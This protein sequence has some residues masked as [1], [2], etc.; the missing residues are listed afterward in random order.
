V[1]K[2]YSSIKREITF[3]IIVLMLF[4][5]GGLSF[6]MVKTQTESLEAEIKL[7]GLSIAKNLAGGIGD[8]LLTDDELGMAR[9]LSDAMENKGVR[10]AFVVDEKEIIKAHNRI[11]R[12]GGRYEPAAVFNVVETEPYRIIIVERDGEKIINFEVPAVARGRLTL[13]TVHLGISYSLITDVLNDVYVKIAVIAFVVIVL[14]IAGAFFLG[15]AITKPIAVLAKGAGIIGTGNLDYKVKVKTK[16]ELGALAGVLNMMTRD[17]KSA[18]EVVIKQ[19]RM[20]K[21]LEVARDIQLSLI[22]GNLEEIKGYEVAAYY[23]SAKEVGGDYYDLMPLGE[24]KY[25]FVMGDVSGKGIPAALIMTMCRSILHAESRM[26]ETPDG[27]IRALN[28]EIYRDMHEGMFVTIF[29]AVLDTKNN[30]LNMVSAG[31][32]DTLVLRSAGGE[33]EAYNPKGFPIGTDPGPR[34]DKVLKNE[35]ITINAGDK[36]AIF[37][38]GISEAMNEAREEYGQERLINIMKANTGKSSS[39]IMKILK[40]DLAD[41]VGDYEQSDDI[42]VMIFEKK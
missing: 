2:K 1:A 24:G 35:V 28:R 16:N 18:Q 25:G 29:Y 34:F 20:E 5:I 23:K 8:A 9:L 4:V 39:E 26:N 27:A 19:Q 3:F 11:E 38:D 15:A 40:K 12:I 31:H 14:G 37:T 42:A 36:T 13:G 32:N 33:V 17:L 30:T 7:R 41:F 21:E 10:Y 6:F 22:P